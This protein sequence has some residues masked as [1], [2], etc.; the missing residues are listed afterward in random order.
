[1]FKGLITFSIFFT[2][3]W[4]LG[5]LL[6][7][8]VTV[9]DLSPPL[10]FQFGIIILTIIVISIYFII[11]FLKF[12]YYRAYVRNFQYL[13]SEKFI[14]VKSGVFTKKKVT[15]PFSR[16]QNINIVQGVFDRMFKLYTVKIETAGFGGVSSSSGIIRSEGYIPGLK[17]P[18][19]IEKIINQLIHKYTQ[20]IPDNIEEKVF[21][22][23]N[24][25][26]DEFIAYI[27]QKITEVG[28]IK[29]K[30]KELRKEKNITQAELADEIGVSRQTIISL[31][32]GKYVPSLTLAMKIARIFNIPVEKIFELDDGMSL[33]QSV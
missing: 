5:A 25:A 24:L 22:D 13:I 26:F 30:I 20:Q 4:F 1:M 28:D 23:N 8:G 19:H 27:L 31:E 9:G 14:V 11:N 29:T 16:I 32:Q 2:N 12:F 10:G 7:F 33:Q 15:I 18:Y 17:D 21:I 6:V 3:I